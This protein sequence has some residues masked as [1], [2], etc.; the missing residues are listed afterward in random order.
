[1]PPQILTLKIFSDHLHCLWKLPENDKNVS[2]RW[3]LIKRYFSMGIDTPI[4]HRK[5][6]EIWQRRF[7]EHMIR[8]E[9][10]WG[11]GEPIIFSGIHEAE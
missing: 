5:E 6:K 9:K 8:D 3:R 1:M 4:N 7:W 11:A 10:D 2:A